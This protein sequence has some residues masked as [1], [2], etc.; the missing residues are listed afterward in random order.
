M[1]RQLISDKH[2]LRVLNK[3]ILKDEPKTNVIKA[4]G[5]AACQGMCMTYHTSSKV[6]C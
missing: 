1:E 6:F 3:D 4:M 2:I 5:L